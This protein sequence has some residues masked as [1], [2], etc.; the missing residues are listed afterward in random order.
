[1]DAKGVMAELTGRAGG[2]SR[3]KG[4]SMHMFSREKQFYG[5]HGIVGAQVPLGAGLAL[6]NKYQRQWQRDLRLFRRRRGQSGS[7]L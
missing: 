5:G 2:Y 6:A 7:G 4:G 1:M 3:G